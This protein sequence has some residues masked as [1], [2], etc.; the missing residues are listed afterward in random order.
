MQKATSRRVGKWEQMR[1]SSI[2]IIGVKPGSKKREVVIL[3]RSLYGE[4]LERQAEMVRWKW[5]KA[6]MS[7]EEDK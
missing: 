5:R 2:T 1:P 7:V 3:L 4:D 6:G